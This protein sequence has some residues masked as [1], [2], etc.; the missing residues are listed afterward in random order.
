MPKASHSHSLALLLQLTTI[1]YMLEI[2]F[3]NRPA[4]TIVSVKLIKVNLHLKE[5]TLWM[6]NDMYNRAV[7]CGTVLKN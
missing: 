1:D 5:G 2:I 6:L 3:K 4:F 7:L